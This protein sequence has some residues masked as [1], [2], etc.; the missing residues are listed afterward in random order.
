MK[1]YNHLWEQLISDE[2]YYQAVENAT[3][4]KSGKS[5]KDR[6]ARRY[7]EH[8]A[9]LKEEFLDYVKTY[10]HRDH[11]P[12]EVYDGIR[13]KRRKIYVPNVKEQILHHMIVNILKPIFMKPMYEHSYGSIP[14]R[15][16][17]KA[18][19]TIEKWIRKNDKNFKY[20]LKMDI[21]KYFDSVPHDI[22]KR[23]LSKIIRDERFLELLFEVIDTTDVGIPIGFF[24]SQWIANWYLTDLDHYIKEKLGA[25]YYV[26]YMDDMVIAGPNKR[27]LHQIRDQINDYLEKEL[28]L[29]M[30]GNWQVYRFNYGDRGRDLDFMGFRFFR[31]RTVLRRTIYFKAVRKA[32][33]IKNK[34]LN[35]YTARQMLSYM[36][37]FKCTDCYGAYLKYIKPNVSFRSLR[38]Y[39]SRWDKKH[40]KEI[41]YGLV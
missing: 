33:R 27:R 21:K 18:K 5:K 13:R 36:G 10:K 8:A 37:W 2:N 34:G 15:G 9:E 17:H 38:H 6:E 4:H 12:K 16:A 20:I 22:L 39:V 25:K 40:N 24:T 11:K 29:K 1:S 3:K 35:I 19:K 23:K 41:N 14:G 31:N 26:R 28:G 32:R 30:K 7:K